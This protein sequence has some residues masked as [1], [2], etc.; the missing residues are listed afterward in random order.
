MANPLL[1]AALAYAS[2]GWRVFPLHSPVQDGGCTC[3]CDDPSC[4]TAGKHPRTRHGH[5]DAT[6]DAGTIR[7]WWATWPDAN[8]AIATG[9]VSGIVVLDVDPDNGGEETLAACLDRHGPL[10]PTVAVAT[11]GGG[12]HHVFRHPGGEVKSNRGEHGLGPGL[13]VR[14]DGGYIVAAPSLH[15]SGTV[16]AWQDAPDRRVLAPMP[17][18]IGGQR[19]KVGQPRTAPGSE[20]PTASDVV[21]AGNSIPEGRRNDALTRLAGCLRR[22]GCGEATVRAALME[23]NAARCHPPLPE[24]EVARIARGAMKWVPEAD[25]MG[26]GGDPARRLVKAD[27]AESRKLNAWLIQ[28]FFNPH[29]KESEAKVGIR[30]A[31]LLEAAA[32][33]G[34]PDARGWYRISNE[35]I[36]GDK[37]RST[38]ARAKQTI[39]ESS[40]GRAKK[41]LAKWGVFG[42][43]NQR[44]SVLVDVIDTETGEIKT[45]RGSRLATWVK[46]LRPYLETVRMLASLDPEVIETAGITPSGSH[47]C[48]ESDN[49]KVEP[50]RTST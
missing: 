45:T 17:A 38:E 30:L 9:A 40:V 1:E 7:Q 15:R 2:L 21:A 26:A 46:P 43:E 33:M 6:T 3:G 12:R 32:A 24:A 16:Y 39:S 41:Q 49:A 23:E 5:K 20:H 37:P 48:E 36:I 42:I 8:V 13:D 29:L 11:G 34:P 27:L 35:R 10:P 47:D 22:Y 28:A 19:T 25:P 18:W 44:V 4:R 14:A 50:G 31:T